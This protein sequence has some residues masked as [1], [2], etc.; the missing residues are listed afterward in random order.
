MKKPVLVI[1]LVFSFCITLYSQGNRTKIDQYCIATLDYRVLKG[2]LEVTVDYGKPPDSSSLKLTDNTGKV[3]YFTSV[4]QIF[5][6]MG[7]RGWRLIS[8]DYGTIDR[9]GY[10]FRRR[11]NQLN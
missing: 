7:K 6:Y 8:K 11:V 9:T 4:V 2:V 3:L 10:L 1:S 5:N